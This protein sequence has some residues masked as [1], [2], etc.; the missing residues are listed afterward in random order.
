[1]KKIVIASACRTAIGKFGGTL[2]NVPA[3]ELGSIV[4]K[5]AIDR[6]GI[7][8]EQV[9]QV[10]MGCVIQAGLGQNVAR[11]A[12]LKAGL[13][14]ETPAVTVNVVCGSGL[15]C[16]NMAAQMIEAGD[17]DI[18]VA[19]GMENMDM[20]PFALMKA[21]YGYRMGENKL[22]DT[23]VND[24]LW[25]ACGNNVHMGV[26]AENICSDE[27]FQQKYGYSPITREM[28]DEFAYNS[29]VKADKAIKDGAFKEE[30]V[31]VV[32]K[33]KKGDTVF[34]TDE[35]PRLSAPEVLAKLKPAFKK[36]GIVTAGNSSA[37]NDG[38]A[39]VVVMSEE[40]AKELGIT[41]MA[42]WVAGA[43]AGVEPEVMGLGPIAATKKVMAKT[44]LTVADMDLIEANEAFAAQSIAVGEALGF[45]QS[46]LNVNGGAIAL[47]HPV[48][49]S[50]CRILVTLLYAMKHRGAKKGLAT[51][52]IGG[53]MGCATIVEMD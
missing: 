29:Q 36:D 28:L 50:G 10:Y 21:R 15:N 41:P 6:A 4:I 45:D 2:A 31:P 25:D 52:C 40:K 48:G 23:M 20:A 51:L 47:G 13:P 44:G 9:D 3:A 17:A 22:V 26:T 49:A 46:K 14:I 18:V 24:A 11:Q 34:D 5:E 1:M 19:G 39:A 33:G 38:A 27:K 43:L 35:G 12:S 42:T 8:P 37:I 7:K 32:I 30:I 53:G 16:V